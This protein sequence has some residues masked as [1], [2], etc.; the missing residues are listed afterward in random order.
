MMNA[1]RNATGKMV[2]RPKAARND[3]A[4]RTAH[5]G[6]DGDVACCVGTSGAMPW[7]PSFL[8]WKSRLPLIAAPI[9]VGLRGLVF[10]QGDGGDYDVPLTP[11]ILF[12]FVASAGT[13]FLR[14]PFSVTWWLTLIVAYALQTKFLLGV[15]T[16]LSLSVLL[17][18][19][20]VQVVS[21]TAFS[22]VWGG[23]KWTSSSPL[24]IPRVLWRAWDSLVHGLTGIL[25][26]HW[27]A[28]PFATVVA[29]AVFVCAVVVAAFSSR[30]SLV[31]SDTAASAD[32]LMVAGVIIAVDVAAVGTAVAAYMPQ[33]A[34]GVHILASAFEWVETLGGIGT[35]RAIVTPMAALVALPLNALWLWGVS[36]RQNQFLPWKL[37]PEQSNDAYGVPLSPRVW[38][39]I[40]ISHWVVCAAWFACLCLPYECI[41]MYALYIIAGLTRQPFTNAWW[42]TFLPVLFAG[43]DVA[44]PFL[45]ACVGLV[46]ASVPIGF[47]TMQIVYPHVFM[48]MVKAWAIEPVERYA[49][50]WVS[51]RW[52]SFSKTRGFLVLARAG[53]LSLHVVPTLLAC[54][55]GFPHLTT[56]A[57]VATTPVNFFWWVSYSFSSGA[58]KLADTNW[59]YGMEPNMPDRSWLILYSSLVGLCSIA[60]CYCMYFER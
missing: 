5:V 49:P 40:L 6:D 13:G 58:T 38:A 27:H 14:L 26:L 30:D 1:G 33:T 3:L 54:W 23:N 25:V 50:M 48:C 21:P 37:R 36:V 45:K 24:G 12:L 39:W 2:K 10:L 18:W 7:G 35:R 47:Y 51:S 53:D 57:V 46:A 42:M 31:A 20:G 19:Y 11:Q 8:V 29:T 16:L 15:A 4:T 41:L 17:G 9:C 56:P 28:P 32:T 55:W 22:A 43:D 52:V 60:L 44:T 59:I 34:N